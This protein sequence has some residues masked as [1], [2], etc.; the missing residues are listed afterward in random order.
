[1]RNLLLLSFSLFFTIPNLFSQNWKE[2]N[3]ITASEREQI[4]E[5]GFAVDISGDYAIVGVPYDDTGATIFEDAG[6]AYIFKKNSS[7][8]YEEVNKII[9][10]DIKIYL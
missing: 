5:F 3:K 4:D 8:Q 6:A 1:M 10:T 2:Q 9:P 7:G